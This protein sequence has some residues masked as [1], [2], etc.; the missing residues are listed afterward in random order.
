L[1]ENTWNSASVKKK[2]QIPQ[3]ANFTSD[4]NA[5]SLCEFERDFLRRIGTSRQGGENDQSRDE[6][7][8]LEV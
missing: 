5:K 1:A 2:I 7:T 4:D 3:R 8:N 6:K